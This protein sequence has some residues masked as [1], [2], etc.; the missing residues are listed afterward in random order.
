MMAP[1]TSAALAI[2]IGMRPET[3]YRVQVPE[4]DEVFKDRT[5]SKIYVI[6][7]RSF[8]K[9]GRAVDVQ[10]RFRDLQSAN[11]FQLSLIAVFFGGAELETAIHK[12]FRS[13]RHQD[14]WFRFD[15]NVA[16][17]VRRGCSLRVVQRHQKANTFSDKKRR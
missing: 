5:K 14:E 2:E 8:V 17:W 4:I 3:V 13:S 15:R 10:N 7:C 6:K 12:R 1:L 9:I 11:P 16:G